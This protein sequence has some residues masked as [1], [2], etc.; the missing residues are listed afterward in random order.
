MAV[1]VGHEIEIFPASGRAELSTLIFHFDAHLRL[2]C[3][4]EFSDS[5]DELAGGRLFS[6]DMFDLEDGRW[7]QTQKATLKSCG[8][9]GRS[10]PS[11]N[12]PV[13]D[14]VGPLV[15]GLSTKEMEIS[16]GNKNFTY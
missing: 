5:W 14:T 15:V 12:H 13:M 9:M 2:C 16:P 7:K 10:E 6:V 1:G 4:L 3:N 11:L 8:L